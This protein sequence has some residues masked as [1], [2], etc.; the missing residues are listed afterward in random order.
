MHLQAIAERSVFL[1][2]IS[3]ALSYIIYPNCTSQSLR[4]KLEKLCLNDRVS[5]LEEGLGSDASSNIYSSLQRNLWAMLQKQLSDTKE[6]Q[7]IKTIIENI[8]TTLKSNPRSLEESRNYSETMFGICSDSDYGYVNDDE[9]DYSEEFDCD[10]G[11]CDD[12]NLLDGNIA[13]NH[14][15]DEDDA[16]LLHNCLEHK[17]FDDSLEPEYESLLWG[18]QQTTEEFSLFGAPSPSYSM[19]EGVDSTT[20]DESFLNPSSS[21]NDEDWQMATDNNH[22]FENMLL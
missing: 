20:Y 16:M 7:S 17:I 3:H 22:G 13:F 18:D 5:G 11:S 8:S 21:S 15:E 14:L 6:A 12:E 2:T 1:P 10:F 19:L 9:H 4:T